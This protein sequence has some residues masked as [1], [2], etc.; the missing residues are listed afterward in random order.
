METTVHINEGLLILIQEILSNE[1]GEDVTVEE[2]GEI[3]VKAVKSLQV[4]M[5]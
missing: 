3:V 5:N 2:V 4:P 1:R